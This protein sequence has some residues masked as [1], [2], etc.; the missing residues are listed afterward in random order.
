M[1]TSTSE[2]SHDVP[3][4]RYANLAILLPI[5]VFIFCGAISATVLKCITLLIPRF[6]IISKSIPGIGGGVFLHSC[7]NSAHC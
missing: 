1:S 4:K 2:I 7:N 5:P 6:W 3:S